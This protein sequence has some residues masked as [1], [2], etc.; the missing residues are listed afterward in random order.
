[1]AFPSIDY[2]KSWIEGYISILYNIKYVRSYKFI[3]PFDESGF[4]I[5][6]IV[7]DVKMQDTAKRS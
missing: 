6:M 5:L 1:M 7:N 3:L 2:Y 4:I